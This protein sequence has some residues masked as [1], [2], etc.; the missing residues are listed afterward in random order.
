MSLSRFGQGATEGK[1]Q[2]AT[3]TR[4][5][6]GLVPDKATIIE[7]SVFLGIFLEVILAGNF[8]DQSEQVIAVH[9]EHPLICTSSKEPDKHVK[10]RQNFLSE[11][12]YANVNDE[13]GCLAWREKLSYVCCR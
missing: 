2:N 1:Q 6:L 11:C 3:D 9:I 5:P 12:Q 4:L 10:K 8:F 7:R 13:H